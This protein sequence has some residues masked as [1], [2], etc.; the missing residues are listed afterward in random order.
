MAEL[1]SYNNSF[2]KYFTHLDLSFAEN[3]LKHDET[4]ASALHLLHAL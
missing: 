1:D 4:G 3:L 2:G